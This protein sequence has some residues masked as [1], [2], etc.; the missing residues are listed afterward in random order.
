MI[1]LTLLKIT[2]LQKKG[3]ISVLQIRFFEALDIERKDLLED[4]TLDSKQHEENF[5]GIKQ[6]NDRKA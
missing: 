1:P 5:E 2:V 6:H 3:S 4:E